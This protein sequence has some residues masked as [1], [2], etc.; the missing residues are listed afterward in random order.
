MANIDIVEKPIPDFVLE[1][2]NTIAKKEGFIDYFIKAQ[3]G[4]NIHDGLQSVMLRIFIE[5]QK[6]GKL[7]KL[8]LICKIPPPDKLRTEKFQTHMFF[9]REILAYQKFLPILDKFQK[10]KQL[11]DSERFTAF[12]K[13]YAIISDFENS[14]LAIIM[15]DLKA[16]NYAVLD[17]FNRLN[18]NHAKLVLTNLGK[19]HAISFAIRDQNPLCFAEFQEVNAD[20]FVRMYGNTESDQFFDRTFRLAIDSLS[21]DET[22]LIEKMNKV[23]KN[24]VEILATVT[25][26]ETAEPFCVLNHGDSWNNNFMY[27]YG[28]ENEPDD[29]CFVDW[30]ILQYGSPALD[31]IYFLFSSTEKPLRDAYFDEF[32]HIYY[33][34]FAQNL[35]RL[36]SDPERLF[37][38]ANLNEQLNKFAPFGLITSTLLVQVMSMDPTKAYKFDS[39]ADAEGKEMATELI[40]ENNVSYKVRMSDVIRDYFKRFDV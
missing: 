21:S 8:S 4:S 17:K 35:I 13:C 7:D 18:Q 29:I 3:A 15:E 40:D 2:V 10:D 14:K 1:Q 34:A 27:H 23:R 36:G 6:Q 16:K 33:V 19:F 26:A 30:Q 31:V 37:S 25:N 22:I 38:L 11:S 5:G 28:N 24:F 20:T 39:A 12:P 32:I 9:K